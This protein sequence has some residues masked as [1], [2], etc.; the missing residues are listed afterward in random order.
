MVLPGCWTRLGVVGVHRRPS[1][2]SAAAGFTGYR[3]SGLPPVGTPVYR[4]VLNIYFSYT[5][6]F[7]S[8][9]FLYFSSLFFSSKAEEKEKKRKRKG[10]EK[11]KKRKRKGEE[12]GKKRKRKGEEK[13]EKSRRKDQEKKSAAPPI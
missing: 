5:F 3:D 1:P 4:G 6:L 10:K 11:G 8:S 13:P 12:K 9:L 2:T 7:F